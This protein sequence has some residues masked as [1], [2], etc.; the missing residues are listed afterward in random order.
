MCALRP[1]GGRKW[2]LHI[3]NDHKQ[4]KTK[5]QNQAGWKYGRKKAE[6]IWEIPAA[7]PYLSWRR[8]GAKLRR[9]R[10]SW[11]AAW[12]SGLTHETRTFSRTEA[13]R[14]RDEAAG[15]R[16]WWAAH[17]TRCFNTLIHR[18]WRTHTQVHHC[19]V[20]PHVTRKSLFVL[21]V[22]FSVIINN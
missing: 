14:R 12:R 5:T 9:W 6:N 18:Q 15:S 10:A 7:C 2:L 3:T 8:T 19:N 22:I 16:A 17:L 1:P 4:K 21:Y 13:Q 20:W 11:S